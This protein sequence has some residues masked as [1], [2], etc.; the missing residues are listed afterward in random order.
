MGNQSRR[1]CAS[2]GRSYRT[3]QNRTEQMAASGS[4]ACIWALKMPKCS[5]ITPMVF[6]FL[7]LGE[8]FLGKGHFS[9]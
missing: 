7:I 4:L 2:T 1:R 5:E 9:R 8:H 3:E 6:F